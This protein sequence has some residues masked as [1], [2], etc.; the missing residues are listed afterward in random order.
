MGS[1]HSRYVSIKMILDILKED[2][3]ADVMK[4]RRK[5]NSDDDD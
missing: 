1:R 5:I 4:F 3:N 2:N